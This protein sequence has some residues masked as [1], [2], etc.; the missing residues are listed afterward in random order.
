VTGLACCLA[1]VVALGGAPPA[2]VTNVAIEGSQL[3][4]TDN[5]SQADALDAQPSAVGYDVFD[6]SSDLSAGAGCVEVQPHHVSC[7]GSVLSVTAT[8]AAA[9]S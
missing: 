4:I 5:V 1:G 3:R 8:P 6:D 9:T 7:L 2:S